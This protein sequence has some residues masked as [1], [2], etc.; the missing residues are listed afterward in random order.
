M[1][2]KEKEKNYAPRAEKMFATRT[3]G[4]SL[5]GNVGREKQGDQESRPLSFQKGEGERS[6]SA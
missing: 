6:S 3:R 2:S 4:K 1:N 5:E